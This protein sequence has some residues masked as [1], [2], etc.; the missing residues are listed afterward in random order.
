MF[1]GQS[2]GLFRQEALFAG[3]VEPTLADRQPAAQ[4]FSQSLFT[5]GRGCEYG[6]RERECGPRPPS[7][8]GAST[9]DV[10]AIAVVVAVFAV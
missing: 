8:A 5:H 6:G 7:V 10:L 1:T 3:H 9:A 2:L 4:F